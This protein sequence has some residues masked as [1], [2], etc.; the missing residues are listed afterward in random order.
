[1]TIYGELLRKSKI[2]TNSKLGEELNSINWNDTVK[3]FLEEPSYVIQVEDCNRIFAIW[4]RQFEI[5]DKDNPALA[6]IREMQVAGFYTAILLSLSLYKP[7]AAAMRTI[8]ET[9]LFYTYFR[10]HPAELATLVNNDNFYIQK[11]EILEYHKIHTR[12]FKSYEAL[13]G[14]V[15]SLNKWYANIS[16][17]IHG[18][19]PGTWGNITKLQDV[20]HSKEIIPKV[21]ENFVECKKIVHNLFLCT[22]GQEL[23]HGFSPTAKKQ[24][25]HGMSG[26]IKTSLQLDSA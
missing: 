15:G 21:I 19:I 7:A 8:L 24:L 16:A 1:M 26:S 5:L 4:S 11:A 6:F 13:F 3:E 2:M 9:A 14:L 10:L 12:N 23:W 18:Q 25:L 22:V 20:K 17:I